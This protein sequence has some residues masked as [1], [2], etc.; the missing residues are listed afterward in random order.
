MKLEFSPSTLVAE[1]EAGAFGVG[2][3]SWATFRTEM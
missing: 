2:L 1:A 3:G